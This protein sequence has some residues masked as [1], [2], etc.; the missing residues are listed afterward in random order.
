MKGG[1]GREGGRGC[2][3][4]YPDNNNHLLSAAGRWTTTGL[5]RRQSMAVSAAMKYP[6][7]PAGVVTKPNGSGGVVRS[8]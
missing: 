3:I 5:D 8:S 7:Y 6:Q 2:C 1:R 4:H